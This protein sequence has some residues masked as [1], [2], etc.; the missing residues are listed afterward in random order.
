M[1]ERGRF[2][3]EYV[4]T[5]SGNLAF[6]Q[7]PLQ[8]RLANETTATGIDEQRRWLHQLESSR[9]NHVL[10]LASQWHMQRDEIRLTE[11]LIERHK[12]DA[13]LLN[14]TLVGSRFVGQH[15]Q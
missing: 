2:D 6:P 9:V 4:Q 12:R 8:I 13:M 15:T 7:G 14:E 1:S 5:S 3:R 11:K 10:R